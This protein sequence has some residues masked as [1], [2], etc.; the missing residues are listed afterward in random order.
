MT[1]GTAA[2]QLAQLNLWHQHQHI[3][4]SCFCALQQLQSAQRSLDPA[5]PASPRPPSCAP[6]LNAPP[7][8]RART[9]FPS[10]SAWWWATLLGWPTAPAPSA[11]SPTPGAA[12][13]TTRWSR[14]WRVRGGRAL[15]WSAPGRASLGE[16]LGT[17]AS[18]GAAGR[19]CAEGVPPFPALPQ[20]WATPCCWSPVPP[21]ALCACLFRPNRLAA[22]ASLSTPLHQPLEPSLYPS[23]PKQPLSPPH[24]RQTTRSTWWQT[25]A[26]ATRTSRTSTSIWPSSR[27]ACRLCFPCWPLAS[28]P[29]G[30]Q[31]AGRLD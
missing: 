18:P 31:Q 17:G 20:F 24:S 15:P 21:S 14:A 30:R 22:A 12:S 9:A 11:S 27:C 7:H 2:A 23:L 29:A 16:L 28:V 6:T 10:W 13:S 1:R 3:S 26:A 19:G 25:P 5:L 8:P 4:H